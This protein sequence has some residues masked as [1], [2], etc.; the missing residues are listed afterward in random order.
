M[1]HT[2]HKRPKP[3]FLCISPHKTGTTWLY[4][5]L[6]QHPE[7][8]LPHKKELWVL[9]QLGEPYTD[10]WKRYINRTGMPGDNRIYFEAF[11]ATAFKERSKI[12]EDL[13]TLGWWLKFLTLPYS[14]WTYSKLFSHDSQL[15]AGDITPNYYFLKR[16]TVEQ[17]AQHNPDAAILLIMRNP[18]DRAWSYARMTIAEHYG[19]SITAIS[20]DEWISYFNHLHVWWKPYSEQ[21][22]LWRQCFPR[23]FFAFYD[24]LKEQ[25]LLLFQEVCRF[26]HIRDD[27]APLKIN[28]AVY[29]GQPLTISNELQDYLSNQYRDEI[30]RLGN[31]VDSPYL[32]RWLKSSNI[33]C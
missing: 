10:R 30:L 21:I 20:V 11:L 32:E 24:L 5:N 4:L 22:T 27:F 26:L 1:L 6:Q 9:N 7:V 33:V 17:Y 13:S 23:F 8:W 2:R 25:P 19:K 18:I 14:M 31:V 28:Q 29:Q 16:E 15:V 12:I 3:D